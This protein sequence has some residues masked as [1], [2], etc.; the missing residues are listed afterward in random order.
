MGLTLACMLSNSGCK[1]KLDYFEVE[2]SGDTDTD[3]D[4]DSDSDADAEVKNGL[5]ATQ[6]SAGD[7][8][9]CAIT[10]DSGPIVCWGETADGRSTPPDGAFSSLSAG[11]AHTC[12]RGKAR[13]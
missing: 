10:T 3:G 2:T 5:S 6:V 4:T 7:A 11:G 13:S 1:E 12:V 8:H 9:T